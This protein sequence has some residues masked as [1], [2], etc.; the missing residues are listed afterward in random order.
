MF[1]VDRIKNFD[2]FNENTATYLFSTTDL[3]KNAMQKRMASIVEYEALKPNWLLL[4]RLLDY[5]YSLICLFSIFSKIL[6]SVPVME[7]GL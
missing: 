6:E 2:R 7:I 4:S 1:V 3:R 5:K